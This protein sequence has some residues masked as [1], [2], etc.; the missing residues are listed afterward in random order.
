MQPLDVI[1]FCRQ[2]HAAHHEMKRKQV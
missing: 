1:W 2:H